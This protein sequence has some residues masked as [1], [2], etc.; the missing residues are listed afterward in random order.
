MKMNLFPEI[1]LPNVP[2]VEVTW[3]VGLTRH[4]IAKPETGI[5]GLSLWIPTDFYTS[6]AKE[7]SVHSHLT[8]VKV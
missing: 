1:A 3:A 5:L 2:V 6:L 8:L 4:K 7:Y